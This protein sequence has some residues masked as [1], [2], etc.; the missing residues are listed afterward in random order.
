M[1]LKNKLPAWPSHAACAASVLCMT[2]QQQN[3]ATMFFGVMT[4]W[5]A[6]RIYQAWQ[7]AKYRSNTEKL[8]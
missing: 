7:W 2:F 5:I 6:A 3:Y 4:G 8:Y 1:D